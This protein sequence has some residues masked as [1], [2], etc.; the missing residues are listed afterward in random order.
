MFDLSG[1]DLCGF[2]MH[3][4]YDLITHVTSLKNQRWAIFFVAY[5][6]F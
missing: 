2:S 5:F 1:I 4:A 6:I 3:D